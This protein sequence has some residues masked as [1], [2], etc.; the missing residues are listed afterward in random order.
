MANSTV[1]TG[2]G[3]AITFGT[4]SYAF[5][6]TAINIGDKTREAVDI[7]HLGTSTN[8]RKMVGDL[9]DAGSV[10]VEFQFDTLATNAPANSS[11][12]ETVTITFP[13]AAS[14]Q[15]VAATYAGTGMITNV[16]FPDLQTGTVQTGSMTVTWDG[17]TGPTW[18]KATA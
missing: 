4:S 9:Q 15:S 2:H 13:L 18:T 6:W 10:T 17:G 12:A 3:A 5:N 8:M 7:T 11:A 1:D 14:G 16:K